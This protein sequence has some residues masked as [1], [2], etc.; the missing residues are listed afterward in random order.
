V[1]AVLSSKGGDA[2]ISCIDAD[3]ELVDG[4]PAYTLE[5]GDDSL[6]VRSGGMIYATAED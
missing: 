2:E 3:D 6:S 5:A 1:D 4:S